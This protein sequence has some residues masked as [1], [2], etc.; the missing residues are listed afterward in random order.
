MCGRTCTKGFLARVT[1]V[2][3]LI[4]HDEGRD[5]PMLCSI[6]SLL[7][8]LAVLVTHNVLPE[9]SP[10]LLRNLESW[11]HPRCTESKPVF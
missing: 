3:V 1:V 10:A 11:A 7:K 8:M 2:A 4:R 5:G 9:R 6:L